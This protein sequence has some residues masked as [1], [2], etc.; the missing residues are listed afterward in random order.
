MP[1]TEHK[2]RCPMS[3]YGGGDDSRPRPDQLPGWQ[4]VAEREIRIRLFPGDHFYLTTQGEALV[5]DIVEQWPVVPV[6]RS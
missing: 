1:L 3:V 2:V 5:S 6:V 4:R